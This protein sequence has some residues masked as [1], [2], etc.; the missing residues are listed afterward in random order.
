MT[1]VNK[2]LSYVIS[3]SNIYFFGCVQL[4]RAFQTDNPASRLWF[5]IKAH[6][7]CQHVTFSDLNIVLIL[8]QELEQ[9]SSQSKRDGLHIQVTQKEVKWERT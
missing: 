7:K 6:R 5:K 2:D 8:D 1:A 4:L 3:L 9:N